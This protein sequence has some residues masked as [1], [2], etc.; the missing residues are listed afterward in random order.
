[1]KHVLR[2]SALFYILIAILM[3]GIT[4]CADDDSDDETATVAHTG[5]AYCRWQSVDRDI[6]FDT[7]ADMS[8]NNCVRLGV[9]QGVTYEEFAGICEKASGVA[10]TTPCD[11]DDLVIP[12]GETVGMVCLNR[13]FNPTLFGDDVRIDYHLYNTGT[14]PVAPWTL[15]TIY[16]KV[17]T[18]TD[19]TG[20][21]Y[22]GTF[23]AP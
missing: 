3:F 5:D 11:T 21:D 15:E 9:S 4:S 8:V 16:E 6:D 18:G 7:V 13:K 1:M 20:L 17:C 14:T 2:K 19:K 12:E 10:S 23:T 22:E